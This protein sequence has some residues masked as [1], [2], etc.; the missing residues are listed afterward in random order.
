MFYI[1]REL[2]EAVILDFKEHEYTSIH[3]HTHN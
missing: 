3:P 1:I 2:K